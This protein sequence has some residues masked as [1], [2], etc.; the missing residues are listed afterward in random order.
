MS[1]HVGIVDADF[2]RGAELLDMMRHALGADGFRNYYAASNDGDDHQGWEL[3]CGLGLATKGA[4]I[5]G[6]LRYFHVTESGMAAL[7]K[8]SPGKYKAEQK[9]VKP[10]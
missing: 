10:K 6:G 3:L 7:R 5:P 9:G 1:E 8:M 4:N 2:A